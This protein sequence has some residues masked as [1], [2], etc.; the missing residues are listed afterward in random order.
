MK[1][2]Y[3]KMT[4]PELH[5]AR[6]ETIAKCREAKRR[7]D[8]SLAIKLKND[9][10][11]IKQIIFNR[12]QEPRETTVSP[13]REAVKAAR[14]ESYRESMSKFGFVITSHALMRFK[15]RFDQS[16][17]MDRLYDKMVGNPDFQQYLRIFPSGQY[18]LADNCVAVLKSK[19]I[20]TFKNPFEIS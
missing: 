11:M 17:T 5:A 19:K 20:L 3:H 4:L 2:P 18:S 14:E 9:I 6:K 15:L 7:N 1:N 12:N 10:G 8:R 13:E 16:M